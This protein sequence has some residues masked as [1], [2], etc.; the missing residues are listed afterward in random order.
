MLFVARLQINLGSLVQNVPMQIFLPMIEDVNTNS[1]R[2]MNLDSHIRITTITGT[3][4]FKWGPT[5]I[6]GG[7][8]DL[9]VRQ[10]NEAQDIVIPIKAGIDHFWIM[11]DNAAPVAMYAI[12]R[13]WR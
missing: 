5:T 13:M 4:Y 9:L 7:N 8:Q 12:G 3:T 10:N 2:P 11:N 6:S 1:L